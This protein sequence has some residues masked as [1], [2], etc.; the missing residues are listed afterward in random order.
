MCR[1]SQ[2]VKGALRLVVLAAWLGLTGM[3]IKH[4]VSEPTALRS[5]LDHEFKTPS[6][7][8][9]PIQPMSKRTI[10]IID[11]GSE[12]ERSE[13]YANQTLYEFLRAHSLTLAD[14]SGATDRNTTDE[15]QGQERNETTLEDYQGTWKLTVYQNTVIS[16]TLTP[17]RST[18]YLSLPRITN[19]VRGIGSNDTIHYLYWIVFHSE[20]H[21]WRYDSEL[22]TYLPIKNVSHHQDIKLSVERVVGLD[23]RR[24][25]CV[26]D[27]GYFITECQRKCFLDQANCSL[28][29][30]DSEETDEK[31]ICNA[32]DYSWYKEGMAEFLY[33][34]ND[35]E[36]APVTKCD[37]RTPCIK[38]RI[39]YSTLSD[40]TKSTND[41]LNVYI[42]MSRVRRTRKMISTYGL[43]DLLAD[44]GGYLGLLLG[45]SVLSMCGFGHRLAG[46]VA[47][48]VKRRKRSRRPARDEAGEG[49]E[50]AWSLF[51]EGD[52]YVPHD[53]SPRAERDG[54]SRRSNISLD[55]LS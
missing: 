22:H 55:D 46:R 49:A 37:C 16:A 33:G 40:I 13:L 25:P 42:R 23:L 39:S 18:M 8:I 15:K 24:Q 47:R 45:V 9:I 53:N 19:L 52:A 54:Q 14:F 51:K 27:P 28:G 1:V 7:T 41:S 26:E 30:M 11:E 35:T 17:S 43:E 36:D 4:F 48:R 20:D 29:N 10:R 21:F 44:I 6:I 34:T 50:R 38:D 2:L 12:E 31:P 32:S 3:K 5:H